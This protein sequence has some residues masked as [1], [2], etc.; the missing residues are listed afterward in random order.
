MT[1]LDCL[2]YPK[3]D[4]MQNRSGGKIIKFQQSQTLTSHFEIFWSIVQKF[5]WVPK[6]SQKFPKIPKDSLKFSE[7][8]LSSLKFPV[9]KNFVSFLGSSIVKAKRS[10]KPATSATSATSSSVSSS[11]ASS[12]SSGNLKF[13]RQNF[14]SNFWNF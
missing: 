6:S 9:L 14:F 5:P 12:S 10:K 7:V 13:S 2:N 3:C 1:F 11:S 8:P 4:F